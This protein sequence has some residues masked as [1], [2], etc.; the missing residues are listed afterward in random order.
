VKK[1]RLLPGIEARAIEGTI[2]QGV[3]QPLAKGLD[4]EEGRRPVRLIAWTRRRRTSRVE[5]DIMGRDRSR[6]SRDDG[7]TQVVAT[8]GCGDLVV[9]PGESGPG[10]EDSVAVLPEAAR[11][12]LPP[13][14]CIRDGAAA[15]PR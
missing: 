1:D 8:L 4:L 14:L 5:S 3:V 7:R 6:L 13:G 2:G 10:P 15:I 12:T 9:S 11:D